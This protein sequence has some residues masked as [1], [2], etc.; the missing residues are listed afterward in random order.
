[1]EPIIEDNAPRGTEQTNNEPAQGALKALKIIIEIR[2][3]RQ[4]IE[5]QLKDLK[6]LAK[7]K[8]T[9]L[10]KAEG[11]LLDQQGEDENQMILFDMDPTLDPEV[12]KI[13]DDPEI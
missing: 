1:M 5:S 13:I 7:R 2:R 6:Q 12:R 3:A 11:I 4:T 8:I 10:K 9:T